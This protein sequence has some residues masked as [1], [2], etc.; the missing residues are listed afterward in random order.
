MGQ[1]SVAARVR[2]SVEGFTGKAPLVPFLLRAME[3][4]AA[5][6]ME[7]PKTASGACSPAVMP[8]AAEGFYFVFVGGD[9]DE[10]AGDV[11]V[12]DFDAG[13]EDVAG[14][15]L[16]RRTPS[17]MTQLLVELTAQMSQRCAGAR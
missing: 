14:G 15:M 16:K 1:P 2:R 10:V 11:T 3:S 4:M 8:T 9:V 7:L 13:G 12:F 17:S 6:W 5:S